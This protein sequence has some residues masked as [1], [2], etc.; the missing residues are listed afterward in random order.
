MCLWGVLSSADKGRLPREVIEKAPGL[1]VSID[2]SS[3]SLLDCPS[4][5]PLSGKWQTRQLKAARGS[6]QL[7]CHR[8]KSLE[9]DYRWVLGILGTGSP[10]RLASEPHLFLPLGRKLM[11]SLI[12]KGDAALAASD[13]TIVTKM[14]WAFRL[15]WEKTVA[16]GKFL[17]GRNLVKCSKDLDFMELCS[18]APG[19]CR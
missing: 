8:G 18:E 15:E 12:C 10:A 16:W 14:I 2:P 13:L 19:S 4:E 7:V 17:I 6:D 3:G 5:E 1:T 11:S 9:G